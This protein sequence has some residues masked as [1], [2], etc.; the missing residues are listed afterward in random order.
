MTDG[1]K[2]PDHVI[3]HWCW[4]GPIWP[5]E[6]RLYR[7]TLHCHMMPDQNPFSTLVGWLKLHDNPRVWYGWLPGHGEGLVSS[8]APHESLKRAAIALETF[9]GVSEEVLWDPHTPGGLE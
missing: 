7:T 6:F 1:L 5:D 9:A 8:G 3:H 2:V 4:M